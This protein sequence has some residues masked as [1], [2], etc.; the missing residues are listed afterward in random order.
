M[1]KERK[2]INLSKENKT[3]RKDKYENLTQTQKSKRM[4][5][6][7]QNNSNKE[8]SSKSFRMISKIEPQKRKGRYNVYI[9]DD[10]AFGVDEEVLIK[11]ELNKGLHVPKEL[12]DK[13]ENEDSYYKAYQKTLNYLSYS[14]R[15]EKQIRDYLAKHELYH[16]SDRMIEQLK[17]MRLLDDLNFAQSFVRSQAN[18]N[19]KGPRNIEQDLKQ[20]GIK[21]EFIL[22]ALDEYPYEQQLENA[23][24][25]ASKKWEQTSKNSEIESIQKVKAY[26]LNKGYNFDLVDEAIAA[27]DTEKDRD[28]EYNALMKQGDKAVR[29]Y[30]RKYE[31]YELSQRLKGYL[32]NKGYPT[33]LIN[34]YMDEREME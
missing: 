29:R 8:V 21:E 18:I 32:Y 27:I 28:V 34:R 19:Q 3:E 1:S 16:F 20:K 25:L 6:K 26:L 10:F 22:T 11:F 13:I 4:K 17:R 24:G 9:N 30:S 14:L 5:K 31:G 33:E 15:S 2:L 7:E 23:I 12:Q